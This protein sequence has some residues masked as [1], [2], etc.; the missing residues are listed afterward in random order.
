[1][2]GTSSSGNIQHPAAGGSEPEVWS[3][4]KFALMTSHGFSPGPGVVV[5]DG[6]P[7]PSAS[8]VLHDEALQMLQDMFAGSA[9]SSSQSQDRTFYDAA[10]SPAADTHPFTGLFTHSEFFF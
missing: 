6:H 10:H 8:D 7:A 1:M 3:A 5:A 2:S 4:E 9:W